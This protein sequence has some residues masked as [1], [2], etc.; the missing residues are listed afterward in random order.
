MTVS[1][2]LEAAG[3]RRSARDDAWL[4]RRTSAAQQGRLYPADP[5]TVE[6][7]VAVMRDASDDPHGDRLPP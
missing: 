6:E 5:P 2:V 4:S 7:L 3:R 1:V